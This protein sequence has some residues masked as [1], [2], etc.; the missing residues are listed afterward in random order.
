MLYA[1]IGKPGQGKS[2]FAVE[3]MFNAQQKNIQNLKKNIQIYYENS[4]LKKKRL[5]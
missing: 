5:S 4:D 1:I 2:Y 3:R